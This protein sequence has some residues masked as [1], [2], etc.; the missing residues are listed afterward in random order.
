MMKSNL[1]ENYSPLYFLASLGAGGLSVSFYIYLLFL[2]PHGKNV[3][4]DGVTID[5]APLATFNHILPYITDFSYKSILVLLVVA[6][7]GFFAFLHFK[8]LLWNIKEYKEYKKT[9]SYTSLVN[10]NAEVTLMTIPLTFAM[11]VNACF[12]LGAVF[13]PNLWSVVEFMFPLALIAFGVTG[14][15]AMKIFTVYFSRIII[16]G[17]FNFSKNNNLSQMI[18][19]FAF[20]MVGVGFA[21]PGAMSHYIQINAIGIFGAIFFLS[22][23]IM[24]AVLKFILGFKNMLEHGISNEASPSLWIAIPI[25]TL[26]GITLIRIHFGLD[27]HFNA[28]LPSSSLFTLTSTIV[29]LQLIMG[30]I[31]FSVMLKLN[32][33]QEF[34]D[35]KE[36]SPGS[37]ALICPGVAFFVFGLFFINFGLEINGVVDKYSIAYFLIMTPFMYVQFITVRFFFKLAKK[38]GN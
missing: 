28:E 36:K 6:A 1:G 5:P 24:L 13:V 9:S 15:Y 25:L 21:A 11:T 7:I 22:I 19:I 3:V 20:L 18:S 33:F 38:F 17:D 30:L 14:F 35:S 4:V 34:I 31:G 8:L 16:N 37:F 2:I 32:Y 26:I 27:H 29:S 12:V 23:A 10:S